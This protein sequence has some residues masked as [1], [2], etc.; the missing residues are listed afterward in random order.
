MDRPA[1]ERRQGRRSSGAL[2]ACPHRFAPPPF[3]LTFDAS[4][5]V[6]CTCYAALLLVLGFRFNTPVL[7]YWALAIFGMTSIKVVS[8]DLAFL[9]QVVKVVVTIGLG[10]VMLAGANLYIRSKKGKDPEPS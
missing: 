6:A 9:D 1:R 3:S 8:H 7:R 5:S 4:G 10:I 2:L